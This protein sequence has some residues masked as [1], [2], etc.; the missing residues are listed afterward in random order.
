MSDKKSPPSIKPIVHMAMHGILKPSIDI[1]NSA[2]TLAMQRCMDLGMPPV[3]CLLLMRQMIDTNLDHY[4]KTVT[5][6]EPLAKLAAEAGID[7]SELH[8]QTR[9]IM[10]ELVEQ[11][12]ADGRGMKEQPLEEPP[13]PTMQ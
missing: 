11:F 12:T 8:N 5:V 4:D 3:L 6:P 10:A 9:E 13:R 7:V 2:F 1:A